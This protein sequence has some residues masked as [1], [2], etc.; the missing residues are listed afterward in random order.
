MAVAGVIATIV[1]TA[2]SVFGQIQSGQAQAASARAQAQ[3]AKAA[4]LAQQQAAEFNV[5]V[6]EN[7]AQ[8]ARNAARV[9]EDNLRRAAERTT[10][11]GTALLAASGVDVG[12]GSAL[13]LAMDDAANTEV[14]AL[15]ERFTGEVEARNALAQAQNARFEGRIR[16]QEGAFLSSSLKLNANNIISNSF[17]GAGS[18]LLGGAA[19]TS[20]FFNRFP[21]G[22]TTGLNLNA[23]DLFGGANFT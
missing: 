15:R 11:T 5:K 2:V 13:L 23:P 7:N 8:A 22:N 16:A 3:Q 9:R 1:S 18:S 10:S 6:A 14:A 19:Q 20:K 17:F 12:T 21:G 4:G